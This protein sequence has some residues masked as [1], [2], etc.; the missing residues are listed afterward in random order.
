MPHYTAAFFILLPQHTLLHCTLSVYIGLCLITLLHFSFCHNIIH[1]Y[2]VHCLYA[3]DY[4]LLHCRLFYSATTTYIVRLDTV[5]IHWI[6]PHYTVAIFIQVLQD[7]LLHCT[8][9]VHIG[10]FLIIL[11]LH[12]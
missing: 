6:M 2:I 10:S 4:A 9:C 12:C 3:L 11:L 1:C 5:C 8:L 7:T